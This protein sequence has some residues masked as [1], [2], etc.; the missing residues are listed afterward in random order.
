MPLAKIIRP[1]VSPKYKELE[2]D[3]VKEWLHPQRDLAEPVIIEDLNQISDYDEIIRLYVIWTRW[4]GLDEV[5]RSE[6]IASA[7]ERAR[8]RNYVLRV[9]SAVGLTPE[10][11][12]SAGVEYAP[13]ET[14]A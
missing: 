3:L 10:E 7:C 1:T 14:T 9:T 4:I 11:A 8:G 12:D 5:E 6:V 13:L 2:D